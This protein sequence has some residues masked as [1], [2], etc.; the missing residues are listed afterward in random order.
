MSA[1]VGAK[2][3]PTQ[4]GPRVMSALMY[5]MSA[6]LLAAAV[7][8]TVRGPTA[9]TVKPYRRISALQ[10]NRVPYL[11]LRIGGKG[12]D[13]VRLD[14]GNSHAVYVLLTTCP[15]CNSIKNRMQAILD[16]LPVGTA[17]SV[18]TE[19]A[20]NL[21]DYWRGSSRIR[22]GSIA[23]IEGFPPIRSVPM[24]LCVNGSGV[25]TAVFLGDVRAALQT[26][27]LVDR[28]LTCVRD[29]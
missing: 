25:V 20:E 19:P 8:V 28:K 24:L 23:D 27:L 29:S 10:G 7:G 21:A 22:L 11:R 5:V 9:A 1:S 26:E 6:A 17:I 15:T 18:S 13:T 4:M 12:E 3:R 14:D 16:S 2:R